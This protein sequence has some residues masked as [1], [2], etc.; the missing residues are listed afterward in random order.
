MRLQKSKSKEITPVLKP[1]SIDVFL[2]VLQYF[3]P[4]KSIILGIEAIAANET[5]RTCGEH[6][7]LKIW[8]LSHMAQISGIIDMIYLS[9][10]EEENPMP[11]FDKLMPNI[12][13]KTVCIVTDI[14]SSAGTEEMWNTIKQDPRVT[15]TI[16]TYHLGLV[17]FRQGQA[18][19]H[20]MIR[21]T[22]SKLLDF[23]LGAKKLWGLLY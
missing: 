3:K 19:E 2:R 20:F 4:E 15:V 17:F 7:N 11:L 8:F 22:T 5:I 18:K 10:K 13:S 23:L 14:H 12:G 16:D 9:A 1:K 21:T 6:L